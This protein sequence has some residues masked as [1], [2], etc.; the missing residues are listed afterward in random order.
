MTSKIFRRMCLGSQGGKI[1]LNKLIW[2]SNTTGR[3]IWCIIL[4]F[5]RN[6]HINSG[7]WIH[8]SEFNLKKA[9]ITQC[10][11]LNGLKFCAKCIN[12]LWIQYKEVNHKQPKEGRD[13][14]SESGK[15]RK[16]CWTMEVNPRMA[17][18][19][20]YGIQQNIVTLPIVNQQCYHITVEHNWF[21]CNHDFW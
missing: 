3:K 18:Y 15:I 14:R 21:V 10:L 19:A 4:S 12:G 17:W 7:L 20:C 11:I 13:N 8:C 6:V 9:E 2:G 5:V 1:V 16:K